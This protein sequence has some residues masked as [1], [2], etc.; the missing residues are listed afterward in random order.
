MTIAQHSTLGNNFHYFDYGQD[1]VLVLNQT[2]SQITLA[3]SIDDVA[4]IEASLREQDTG[5]PTLLSNG[6]STV[7]LYIEVSSICDTS[8]ASV[9]VKKISELCEMHKVV[10]RFIFERETPNWEELLSPLLNSFCDE[11]EPKLTLQLYG[12]FSKIGVSDM[13][14]LHDKHFRLFYVSDAVHFNETS[15]DCVADLAKFGFRVPFVW[16]VSEHNHRIVPGIISE[17]MKINFNSGFLLPL[18]SENF[19]KSDTNN[20]AK[21]EY[22]RL[23]YDVYKSQPFY[24]EI[25]Y[26]MNIALLG[27][28]KFPQQP[29]H[30]T[31]RWDNEKLEFSKVTKSKFEESTFQLLTKMFLWQRWVVVDSLKNEARKGNASQCRKNTVDNGVLVQPISSDP[32]PQV[33]DAISEENPESGH[34]DTKQSDDDL[35]EK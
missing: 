12:P 11:T 27:S 10:A 30:A 16:H 23:L 24:D 1:G 28:I 35:D 14:Y 29:V 4:S 25:F 31:Y 34:F 13:R 9:L 32:S 8:R 18:C 21:E 3:S 6:D 20:P 19:F 5:P 22:L 17:A 33:S 7:F 2:G 15:H 26:P